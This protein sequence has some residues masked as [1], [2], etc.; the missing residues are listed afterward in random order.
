MVCF[1]LIGGI[2]GRMTSPL[3]FYAEDCAHEFGQRMMRSGTWSQYRVI[4]KL[5]AV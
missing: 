4:P 1:I 2:R 5:M 3:K